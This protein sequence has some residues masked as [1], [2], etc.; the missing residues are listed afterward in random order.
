MLSSLALSPSSSITFRNFLGLVNVVSAPISVK[1]APVSFWPSAGK[2]QLQTMTTTQ[3]VDR[4][5]RFNKEV[6][7]VRDAICEALKTGLIIQGYC[8]ERNGMSATFYGNGARY[9]P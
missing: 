8:V 6:I 9:F 3:I 5:K 1:V 2:Y 4:K 7:L